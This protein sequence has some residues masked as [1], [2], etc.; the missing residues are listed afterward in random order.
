MCWPLAVVLYRVHSTAGVARMLALLLV[1]EG[2]TVRIGLVAASIAL[3]VVIMLSSPEI[4][5]TLAWF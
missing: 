3:F 1:I 2:V 5:A 4:G